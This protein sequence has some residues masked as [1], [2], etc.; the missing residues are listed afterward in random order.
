ML[1]LVAAVKLGENEND[2]GK[3]ICL[4]QV[5]YLPSHSIFKSQQQKKSKSTRRP[6]IW[7]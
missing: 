3:V 1:E 7:K 5:F 6:L 4:V 2:K